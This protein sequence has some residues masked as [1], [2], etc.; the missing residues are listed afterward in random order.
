[1]SEQ[2]KI[3]LNPTCILQVPLQTYCDDFTFLVNGNEFKT[4]RL[5][6]DLISPKISKLHL[7][8]PTINQ[9]IINTTKNGN[10]FNILKLV[11]FNEINIIESEIPFFSEVIEIL[12]NDSI[13]FSYQKS[14][15]VS[16]NNVISLLHQHEQFSIFYKKQLQSEIEFASSH[17]YEICQ[18]ERENELMTLSFDTLFKIFNNS[19][20]K[21]NSED[22]L[23]RFINRLYANDTKFCEMYQ[24]VCFMNVTC[25]MINE[26]VNV[27]N[28]FDIT[29]EIWSKLSDRLRQKV[30]PNEN[31]NRYKEKLIQ[32]SA[33]TIQ[34][35]GKTIQFSGDQFNG[36]I[37]HITKTLREEISVTSSSCY[38]IKH[39]AKNVILYDD[40]NKSFES[41]GQKDD[42]ICF[43]FVKR[44]VWPAAYSI[45]SEDRRPNYYNLKSW[46]IEVSNDQ[47]RWEIVDRQDGSNY[48]NGERY[49]HLFTVSNQMQEGF[50]YVR[51][52]MTAPNWSNSNYLIIEAFELFGK[53]E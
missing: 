43:D 16:V 48:L 15:E 19:K 45:R 28:V 38:S 4:S 35:S 11:N 52:R 20:L 49:S 24:F 33:N 44:K 7:S 17:F 46:V 9:F 13:N 29:S 32:S 36:I 37:S 8:D 27:F 34:F 31:N 41:N 47:R 5:I 50:R 14:V 1:M 22:Q 12:G 2:S 51:L 10:F 6:S 30:T 26:F 39:M 21:V 18:K 25:E 53:M 40:Q 42:W 23:L 3:Q